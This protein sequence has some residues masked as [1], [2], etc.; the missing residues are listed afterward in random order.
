MGLA[1]CSSN[2]TLARYRHREE[3]ETYVDESLQILVQTGE[4][5][6]PLFVLCD[7]GLLAL[8]KLLASLLEL[9]SL[10]MLVV[11]ACDHQFMFISFAMLGKQFQKLFD[12]DQR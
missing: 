1:A 9:L 2:G 8:E 6:F 12:R 10:G 5:V 3:G 4:I 7:Q 11:D